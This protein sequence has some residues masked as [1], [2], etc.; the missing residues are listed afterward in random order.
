M[1]EVIA[2]GTTTQNNTV[3]NGQTMMF[4][5]LVD[6]L[7]SMG[8][9]VHIIDFGVS[10]KKNYGDNRVS[11]KFSAVKLIDNILVTLCFFWTLMVNP[12]IPVYINTSQSKVGFIRDV[13]FINLAKFFGR[14]IIGHQFGANYENFYRVQSPF[15]KKLIKST[16]EKTDQFIVEGDYTKKQLDFIDYY[17]TKVMS[18]PNGLPQKI[19]P[20]DLKPKILESPTIILYLSNMI[21][22]KGYWDV[23]EAAKILHDRYGNT[24]NFIFAGKFLADTQDKITKDVVMARDLFF[25]KIK[26]YGLE[27]VITYTEG[28]Y[29]EEKAKV[30]RKAHFF[31]LP[32][33]YIN[34][35]QPVSVLEALAHGTV[36]IVTP[37]RLIP[38]MVN[39]RNGFF[40]PPKSPDKIAEVVTEAINNSKLYAEK[41]EYAVEYFRENFTPEKYVNQILNLF[42]QYENK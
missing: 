34:E 6:Q 11:G 13:L 15:F 2:V 30:F 10:I 17:Q 5:L 23:L 4:Q 36:P 7:R 38:V 16:L 41:S 40:V 27:D 33:Y 32:S 14:V 26:D 19:D 18:I 39:E 21:E 31:V 9:R 42:K 22:G 24:I 20:L 25:E 29:G 37:Y 1:K 8:V 3:V 12:R 28:L 35:G